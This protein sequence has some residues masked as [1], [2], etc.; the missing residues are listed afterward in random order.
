MFLVKL[1]HR[2][3][4]IIRYFF[5]L[6]FL[7]YYAS[8]TL[9]THTHIIDG[10][11]IVHSHPYKSGTGKNPVNHQHTTNGFGLIQLL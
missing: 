6:L 5:L 10:I 3:N 7:A 2:V 4:K 11:T 9:F 1:K 8:V